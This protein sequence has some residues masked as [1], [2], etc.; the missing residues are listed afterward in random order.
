MQKMVNQ[1]N[2]TPL[3]SEADMGLYTGLGGYAIRRDWLA[4]NRERSADS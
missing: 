1:A 4:A 2:A 3:M